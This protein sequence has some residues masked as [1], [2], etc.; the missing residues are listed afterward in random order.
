MQRTTEQP[1][2]SGVYQLLF[3]AVVSVRFYKLLHY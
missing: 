1:S 3:A 2:R